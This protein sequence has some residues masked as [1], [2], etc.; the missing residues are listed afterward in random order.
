MYM[1]GG[2]ISPAGNYLASQ[3]AIIVRFYRHLWQ[4][5]DKASLADG[6]LWYGKYGAGYNIIIGFGLFLVYGLAFILLLKGCC[7]K[8]PE[9]KNIPPIPEE[10]EDDDV[11]A[12]RERVNASVTDARNG[13]ILL[14]K[15]L[16]KKYD[17]KDP[18]A[19][20]DDLNASVRSDR[21]LN[22]AE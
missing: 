2:I 19:Q 5:D 13:D 7:D 6:T 10:F 20:A 17:K 21:P 22:M 15:D 11:K 4:T 3:S 1:V 8:K 9:E 12:E 18:D 16:V 14:V